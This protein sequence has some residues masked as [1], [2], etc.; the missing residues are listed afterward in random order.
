MCFV[1]QNVC[2]ISVPIVQSDKKIAALILS[3]FIMC[4]IFS[5][6]FLYLYLLDSAKEA[7]LKP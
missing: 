3:F 5:V 6:L 2:V 1:F 4:I 7:N